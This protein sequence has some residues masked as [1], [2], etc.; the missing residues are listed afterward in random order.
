MLN[1]VGGGV[2]REWVASASV[3]SRPLH[4]PLFTLGPKSGAGYY[5]ARFGPLPFA[6]GRDE[7]MDTW[8]LILR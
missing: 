7:T 2:P 5:A 3:S 6:I 1:S 4:T 8:T